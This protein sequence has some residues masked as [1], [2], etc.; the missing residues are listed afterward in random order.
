ML[1]KFSNCDKYFIVVRLY[2]HYDNIIIHAHTHT[3]VLFL[4]FFSLSYFDSM[5]MEWLYLFCFCYFYF[6]FFAFLNRYVK[7]E[8]KINII[9]CNT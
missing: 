5:M 3:R 4:V 2:N 1:I 7:L 9:S 8:L 6:Y